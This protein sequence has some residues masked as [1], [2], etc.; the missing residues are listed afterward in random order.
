MGIAWISLAQLGPCRKILE[1]ILFRSSVCHG[2][3]TPS[4]QW[5]SL[6]SFFLGDSLIPCEQK[7]T[8]LSGL[9]SKI[10]INPKSTN[11]LRI[12]RCSVLVSQSPAVLGVPGRKPFLQKCPWCPFSKDLQ[13]SKHCRNRSNALEH[14]SMV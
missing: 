3:F 6:A 13:P 10:C 11:T 1:P 5:T 2:F 9:C 7:N 8:T 12:Y 4:S 14:F